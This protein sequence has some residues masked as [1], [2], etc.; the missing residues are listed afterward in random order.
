MIYKVVSQTTLGF[1]ILSEQTTI[2][3][4][5]LISIRRRRRTM[6]MRCTARAIITSELIQIVHFLRPLAPSISDRKFNLRAVSTSAWSSGVT[7]YLVLEDG[8]WAKELPVCVSRSFK[9]YF[10]RPLNIETERE[11]GMWFSKL[12]F[13]FSL[14]RRSVHTHFQAMTWTEDGLLS[15][16]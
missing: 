9:L 4:L 14:G 16:H 3:W 15:H 10:I 13:S 1:Y 6:C 8:W 12:I 2:D 11:G 5:F 7:I